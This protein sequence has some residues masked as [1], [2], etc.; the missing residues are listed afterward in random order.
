MTNK[1]ARGFTLIELLVIILI[2]GVFGAIGVGAILVELRA[3]RVQSAAEE[4]SGWLVAVRRASE[5]GI[6]CTVSIP[7]TNPVTG[8]T[9][10][11]TAVADSGTITNNCL[12]ADPLRFSSG[13]GQATYAVASTVNQFV[14][15]PRGTICDS[16][17]NLPCT[18][19]TPIAVTINAVEGGAIVGNPRRVCIR[20]PL[21]LIEVAAACP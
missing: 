2:L 12:S 7:N 21:G 8:T 4:L 1:T 17:A 9:N 6:P 14:F 10:V 13:N 5:R 11:A 16:D 18:L 15:T 19:A 20:P 3:A